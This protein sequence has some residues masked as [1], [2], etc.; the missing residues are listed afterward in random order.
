MRE[1][2]QAVWGLQVSIAGE[3]GWHVRCA[4]LLAC[5]MCM[6]SQKGK[7]CMTE[8]VD[9]CSGSQKWFYQEDYMIL[10]AFFYLFLVL[11][12]ALWA[13]GIQVL[14]PRLTAW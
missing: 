2:E 10:N 9:T 4:S 8:H 11:G 5:G 13:L 14:A 1:S 12:T 6:L 7:C 3:I